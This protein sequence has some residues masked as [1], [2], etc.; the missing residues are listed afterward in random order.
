M[1]QYHHHS[2]YLIPLCLCLCLY[3]RKSSPE[4]PLLVELRRKTESIYHQEAARM[5]SG[6]LQGRYLKL[7]TS[8][9]KARRVLE[10]GSFVGYSALCLAEGLAGVRDS[11][12]TDKDTDTDSGGYLVDNS[13]RKVVTCE[14]DAKASAIAKE[15]F[16]KSE[17][18]SMV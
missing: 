14:S 2:L 12:D 11:A 10:L 13:H 7:L 9:C 1:H 6:P 4:P 16:D 18:K 5:L 3:N 15:Y 8:L 17:Y